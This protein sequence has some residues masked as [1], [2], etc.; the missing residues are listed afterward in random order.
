MS[1]P[2]RR[3]ATPQQP[4]TPEQIFTKFILENQDNLTRLTRMLEQQMF[5]M[6]SF[7]VQ[8]IE[9]T[10]KPEQTEEQGNKT[11]DN[12]SISKE[13]QAIRTEDPVAE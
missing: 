6:D 3:N 7:L 12:E 10:T 2:S 5:Y 4:F 8:N 1:F 11:P 13:D 9:S